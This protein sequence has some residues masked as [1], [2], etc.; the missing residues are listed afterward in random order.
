MVED[1][2]YME[3]GYE[4]EGMEAGEDIGIEAPQDILSP[5]QL[6]RELL[7]SDPDLHILF[8][9]ELSEEL[10]KG[11]LDRFEYR[12]I[13][14][15]LDNI[16][17]VQTLFMNIAGGKVYIPQ[18]LYK[19]VYQKLQLSGSKHMTYIKTLLTR[20]VGKF[21]DWEKKRGLFG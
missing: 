5:V 9:Y 2:E 1:E 7:R 16:L 13:E 14:D 17:H 20:F 21:E 19:Q 10:R 6:L 12:K 4:G 15:L 8:L 18:L 11:N 3:G